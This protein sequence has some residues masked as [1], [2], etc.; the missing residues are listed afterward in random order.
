MSSR[1]LCRTLVA[2]V[3]QRRIGRPSDR[4]KILHDHDQPIAGNEFIIT[5]LPGME[6]A[7][8]GVAG[9]RITL[10]A[11]NLPR[12]SAMSGSPG[13]TQGSPTVA[14]RRAQHFGQATGSRLIH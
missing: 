3:K 5:A 11:G 9:D 12:P 10:K 14:P 7:E 2:H 6:L 13:R 4:V 1:R 8:P